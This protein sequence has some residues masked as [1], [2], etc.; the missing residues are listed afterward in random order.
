M[1][2]GAQTESP[3]QR[4]VAALGDFTKWFTGLATAG[5]AFSIGLQA[6]LPTFSAS[7]RAYL[8]WAWFFYALAVIAGVLVQSSFP[9]L[10]QRRDT[11]D[12]PFV[13]RA[14]AASFGGLTLGSIFTFL[15]LWAVAASQI[16]PD[17]LAIRTAQQAVTIATA[18]VKSGERLASID[19]VEILGGVDGKS[20]A[21]D[22]WHIQLTV[23]RG[24][25]SS[26]ERIQRDVYLSADVGRTTAYDGVR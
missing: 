3:D 20:L 24:Q 9:R 6:N 1:A 23:N 17:A 25:G 15:A 7:A 14:Y 11:I 19:K 13:K 18:L 2:N 8:V 16:A 21:D 26:A 12:N 5:L 4:A 10:I 22:T